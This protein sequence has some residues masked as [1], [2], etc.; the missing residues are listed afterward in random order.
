[1]QQQLISAARY[2]ERLSLI[3][4]LF[5]YKMELLIPPA[6]ISTLCA[7]LDCSCTRGLTS[8]ASTSLTIFLPWCSRNLKWQVQRAWMLLTDLEL[9]Q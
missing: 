4:E 6:E 1:M 7:Q 2:R 9:C 3:R 8:S 5:Q